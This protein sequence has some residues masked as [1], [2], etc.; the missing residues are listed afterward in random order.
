VWASP[1]P[2][3]GTSK[4]LSLPAYDGSSGWFAAPDGKDKNGSVVYPFD[5]ATAL[6]SKNIQ[7]GQ[8]LWLRGGTY[9]GDFVNL[10]SGSDDVNRITIRPYNKETVIIDGSLTNGKTDGSIQYVDIRNIRI[11]NSDPNRGSELTAPEDITRAVGYNNYAPH[12]RFLNCIIDNCG[13]SV[14]DWSMAHDALLYGVLAINGGWMDTL[15]GHGHALYVQ[16]KTGNKT[17]KHCIAAPHFGRTLACY[18]TDIINGFRML[19]NVFIEATGSALVIG[20]QDRQDD[21]Q[22]TDNHIIGGLQAQYTYKQNG[23]LLCANNII[24]NP[25]DRWA[26]LIGYWE[27][28]TV[29][30]NAVNGRSPLVDVVIKEMVRW[31][32]PDDRTGESIVWNGNEYHYLGAEA[33]MFKADGALKDFKAW[34]ALGLDANGTYDTND[35]LPDAVYVYPNEY[36]DDSDPR[37]G[38]VVIWNG[39]GLDSVEVDLTTLDLTNGVTYNLIQSLDP[40]VDVAQFVADGN[41]LTINMLGHS[42][43]IPT[44]WNVALVDS[45][46]PRFGAFVIEEA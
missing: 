33:S 43:A 1:G 40:F 37:M 35:T 8:T 16:N 6:S 17:I 25:A 28:P 11:T 44:G 20:G 32:P 10:L 13:V 12:A 23:S 42:V 31:T 38:I 24:W 5:L 2:F 3:D 7:P 41:P 14:G 29:T 19:E 36:K 34:Q 26:F 18:G 46:F 27:T 45:T 9:T 22:F 30:G 39:S 15:R 21:Q 4:N